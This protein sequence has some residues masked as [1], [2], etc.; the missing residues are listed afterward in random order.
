MP[1]IK[2]PT[3]FALFKKHSGIAE[4]VDVWKRSMRLKLKTLWEHISEVTKSH[5]KGNDDIEW[6]SES[7]H[8]L[9]S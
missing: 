4:T 5:P 6:S 7:L 9:T 8:T 3:I 1:K 2:S